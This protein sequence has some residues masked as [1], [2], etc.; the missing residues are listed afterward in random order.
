MAG[1]PAK[2]S[3]PKQMW[4]S[5]LAESQNLF[6]L[7]HPLAVRGVKTAA[8][9]F[10]GAPARQ[11]IGLAFLRM[12]GA[13]E[14]AVEDVF[15]RYLVGASTSHG[16]V[17]VTAASRQKTL[18]DAFVL[19]LPPH[20]KTQTPTTAYLTWTK[21]TEVRARAKAHLVPG[22]P[23]SATLLTGGT[24][25]PCVQRAHDI[26]HRVAHPSPKARA[27]FNAIAINLGAG[28]AH[29]KLPQGFMV[30]DLLMQRPTKGFP[31]G[32]LSQPTIFEAY[33]E[34]FDQLVR[35]IAP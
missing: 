14:R 20:M 9:S 32:A 16:R 34:V 10:R 30:G 25:E 33:A 13:W 4:S 18:D 28:N 24:L 12:V 6:Q 5:S 31:A 26:R 3:V 1:R 22:D 27:T 35:G 15:L 8:G 11:V 21:W 7:A 23:I 19:L 17:V 29:G 2:L